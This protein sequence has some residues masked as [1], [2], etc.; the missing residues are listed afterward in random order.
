M[1]NQY[2]RRKFLKKAFTLTVGTI[3]TTMA[4]YS[5]VRY[6]EP[7]QLEIN[8]YTYQAPL[9]PQS[10]N[11]IKIL[12]FSDTHVGHYYDI[13][14]FKTL[15]K[16]INK[17]E[18]DLVFFTGDLIDAPDLYKDGNSLIPLLSSIQAPLGKFAIYGNHD[19]GG[20]GTE[21]YKKIMDKSGFTLLVNSFSPI[22]VL[23]EQIVVAG[24]DD[25]MLGRPDFEET[26]REIPK[27]TF[28]IFLAHEPDVAKIS[29]SYPVH[30]QLSGHSHGGQIKLPFFGPI[31][32]P[33]F[34]TEYTEGFYE[35]GQHP[36]TL[37]VNRGLGTTRVPFRFLSKPEIAI[38]TLE[39]SS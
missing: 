11:G 31:V 7:S 19:H 15:I 24:L 5:Y 4:G 35:L 29:Q 10:F 23:N 22:N 3:L 21:T 18:P 1:G 26:L 37:Y 28:T 13:E 36:L 16:K 14:K 9:I 8:R 39:S 6:F 25:Y 12:Q 38:F 20:Y 33:P 30:L 32:T 2:T 27:D 17:E 34:A